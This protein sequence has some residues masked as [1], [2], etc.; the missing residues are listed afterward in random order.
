MKK[1]LLARSNTKRV[2]ILLSAIVLLA[3]CVVTV[4]VARSETPPLQME[5][6]ELF[7]IT[8]GERMKF[9]IRWLGMEVGSAE[10][11]VKEMVKVGDRDAFHVVVNVRSNKVISLIYPVRD[12][13]HSYIDAEHFHSLKYERNI[14]EG[15]YR[16]HERVEYDQV[17]HKGRYESLR[18]GTVKEMLIPIDV[19]DQISCTYWFRMQK[20]KPGDKV[21]IPVNV[22]EKNWKLVVE[23]QALEKI[24]IDGFGKVLAFRCEPFA[25]FQALFVRRGR[26]WGWM[27]ADRRRI[28]LLMKTKIPVL[29][30]INMVIKEYELGDDH[31]KA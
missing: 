9:G 13:H 14:K 12:E 29:G 3:V 15:T 26:A 23:A 10:V 4:D 19:Q 11:E 1:G 8:V 31:V 25:K 28:P 24:K 7:R 18:S 27:S 6:E 22:D 2:A 16:A 20:L 21:E 5:D 30:S 17:N